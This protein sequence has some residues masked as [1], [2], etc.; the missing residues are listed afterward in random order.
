[1]NDLM[2]LVNDLYSDIFEKHPSKYQEK[3]FNQEQKDIYLEFSLAGVKK[4]EI[5]LSVN[6]A[7]LYLVVNGKKITYDRVIYVSKYHDI[8]K[9]EAKYENGLLVI[10]IPLKKVE[11]KPKRSIEIK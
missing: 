8:D 1:M 7:Y 2:Q 3:E 4:D 6:D 5:S 11:E 9:C 10:N